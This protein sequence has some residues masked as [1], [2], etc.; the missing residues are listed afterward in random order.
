MKI[1]LH[2]FV[3]LAT[4]VILVSCATAPLD[5]NKLLDIKP[6][7]KVYTSYNI[8]YENRDEILQINYH[9]GKILSFGTEVKILEATRASV[10][11]QVVK[12]GETYKIILVRKI[13]VAK[14]EHYISLLFTVKNADELA[15]GIKPEVLEKIKTGTV[16]KGMRKQEVILAYGYPPPHRTPS[17]IEDT[18]IYFDSATHKKRVM[19][20]KKGL[21]LEIMRDEQEK[22]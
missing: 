10:V 13:L 11:F 20:S 21:V 19:F 17:I 6:D 8:W 12:T 22:K 4:A 18:W 5:V 2:I 15:T 3:V 16:E 9:K 14:T 1:L 7:Q